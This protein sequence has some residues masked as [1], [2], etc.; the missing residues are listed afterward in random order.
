MP[1]YEFK[2]NTCTTEFETI[3]TSFAEVGGVKCKQCGSSDISRMLSTVNSTI[4]KTG[5]IPAAA[6]PNCRSKSGFS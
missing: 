3:V 4:K 5:T 2:C 6:P 1:I